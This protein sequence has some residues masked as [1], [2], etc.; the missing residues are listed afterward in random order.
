MDHFKQL[1]SPHNGAPLRVAGPPL[2]GS[3]GAYL[4]TDGD[5]L[6]PV[7][8]GIAY[9]RPRHELREQVVSLLWMDN[10]AEARRLLLSDQD[11]FSPTAPPGAAAL[12]EL[13]DS[14]AT[15]TLRDA[16]RLLNYGPVA[17]Y[18]AYR[19]CTPTFLSGL[20]LLGKTVR[21]DRP[22][23]EFACGIGH[24]LRTLEDQGLQ[25]TGIDIVFSKLWL[26]RR[27]L[28]VKGLLVCG[29]IEAGPVLASGPARTVFCH[30]AFYFFEQKSAALKNMRTVAG[31]GNLAVGHVHTQLDVHEAGFSTSLDAYRL[32]TDSKLCDDIDA[33]RQWY[34]AEAPLAD[35][36]KTSPAIGWIEGETNAQ[37]IDWHSERDA[38]RLNPLIQQTTL[39]YPS[40]D[41]C[42]EYE[43][44]CAELQDFHLLRLTSDD[45]LVDGLRSGMI[46]V[47]QLRPT[48]RHAL[49][50]KRILID[51]PQN[52]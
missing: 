31:G 47:A 10:I 45:P 32:L 20:V 7:V 9:L 52:W 11:R 38:L 6:W 39:R 42:R 29:D 15:H 2:W 24:F 44:D 25:T 41:W 14:N 22:V 51:L 50:R 4:L 27:Y 23:V 48:D 19:W 28:D 33:A 17:D 12:D 26:A 49:Y 35:A 43:A 46:S 18:F 3:K 16:M 5:L 13:L 34:G 1:I 8:D 36:T 30:D 37:R 21:A 40:D